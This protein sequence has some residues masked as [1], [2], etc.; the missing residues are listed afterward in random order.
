MTTTTV[1]DVYAMWTESPKM[2]QRYV[3]QRELL[4]PKR[5]EM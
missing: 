5:S 4:V 3:V 1:D 2:F